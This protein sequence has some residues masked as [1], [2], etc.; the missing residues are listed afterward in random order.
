MRNVQIR[1]MFNRADK[2]PKK[3]CKT[4]TRNVQTNA[5]YSDPPNVE[6]SG[7][8]INREAQTYVQIN[9]KCSDPTNVQPSEQRIKRNLWQK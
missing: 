7:Q 3:N 9:A 1:R 4:I 6:P 5:K 2:G 8:V